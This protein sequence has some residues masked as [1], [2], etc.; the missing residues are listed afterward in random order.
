MRAVIATTNNFYQA[1]LKGEKG[2]K[3]KKW[4]AS[5]EDHFININDYKVRE[6]SGEFCIPPI[7]QKSP[8]NKDMISK[9][10]STLK[11]NFNLNMNSKPG[12]ATKNKSI[13]SVTSTKKILLS[14]MEKA[15]L[16]DSTQQ[17]GA[18]TFNT[19]FNSDPKKNWGS[20]NQKKKC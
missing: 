18:R 13:D 2:E 12:F 7:D 9:K 16:K 3:L 6:K 17:K 20:Q 1:P 14:P 4:V 11:N 5:T 8:R 10:A 15:N 19:S